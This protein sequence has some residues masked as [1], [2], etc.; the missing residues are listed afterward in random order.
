MSESD[1]PVLISYS[2]FG[3]VKFAENLLRNLNDTLKHHRV[4]F[5]CL[6]DEVLAYLS[7]LGLNNIPITFE[8]VNEAVSKRF[9]AYGS[10]NYNKITHTKMNILCKAVNDFKFIH[11]IDSDV[12]CIKE[13]SAEHYRKYKEYD[14]VFQHDAGFHTA[15]HFHAPTLHHTWTC[16]GNVSL[17]GTEGTAFM[18]NKIS[19]YQ[20]RYPNKNDQECLYKYFQDAGITDIRSLKEAKLYTYEVTEYT[21]GYWLN[22][23]IG[24]L[25]ETYFFHA[26]HVSGAAQKMQLLR[27]A[28]KWLV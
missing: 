23:N 2:N 27:K 26:N 20:D 10:A 1:Y 17:R 24:D 21:N 14:I 6:D 19:E 5:Y 25:S 13:P 8:R 3:Y 18:L 11:F 4:H 9:E 28:G 12:V 22:N 7:G 15:T 16:T